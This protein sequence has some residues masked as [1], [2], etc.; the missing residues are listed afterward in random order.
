MNNK[1]IRRPAERLSHLHASTSEKRDHTDACCSSNQGPDFEAV[2][3]AEAG[4]RIVSA[5]GSTVGKDTYSLF[6]NRID[7]QELRLP[8]LWH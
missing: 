4:T 6:E 3:W 5:G 8:D 2:Q 7:D 1:V